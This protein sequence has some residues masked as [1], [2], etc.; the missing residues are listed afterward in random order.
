MLFFTL[1]CALVIRHAA[2]CGVPFFIVEINVV[3]VYNKLSVFAGVTG[4]RDLWRL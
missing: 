2:G 3:M 4:K 1:N